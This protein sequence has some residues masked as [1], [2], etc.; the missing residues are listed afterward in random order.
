M[1]AHTNNGDNR[2][3]TRG[4]QC[5]QSTPDL[6]RISSNASIHNRS[7]HRYHTGDKFIERHMKVNINFTVK[8]TP[9]TDLIGIYERERSKTKSDIFTAKRFSS[10]LILNIHSK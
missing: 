3:E 9:L 8:L 7:I 6:G 10:W 4:A 5:G 1:K 2:N